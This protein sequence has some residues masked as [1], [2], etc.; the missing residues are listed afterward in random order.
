VALVVGYLLFEGEVREVRDE[1]TTALGAMADLQ[2]VQIESWRRERAGDAEFVATGPYNREVIGRLLAN[3]DQPALRAAVA[4]RAAMIN[5]LYAY[6]TV[7]LV[8]PDGRILSGTGERADVLT[9]SER[10]TAAQAIARGGPVFGNIERFGPAPRDTSIVVAAPMLD[11]AGHA[12]AVLL[13]RRNPQDDILPL[14]ERWPAFSRTAETMLVRR[15]GDEAR[16]LSRLRHADDEPLT[17]TIALARKDVVG[18]QALLAGVS[19]TLEGH[20]Y[21]GV[22]V[23]AVV[24]P[25]PGTGWMLVAKIDRDEILADARYKLRTAALII[26]LAALLGLVTFLAYFGRRQREYYREMYASERERREAEEETR[27]TLYSIGDAVIT[28]DADA[29]VR[30]M[31]PVAAELTGWVEQEAKGRPLHEI[32]RIVD[33]ETRRSVSSPAARALRDGRVVE[34]AGHVLLLARD[35]REIPIAD[36]A[37]PIRAVAGGEASGV[38]LVFRDQTRE[39]EVQK[40]LER[41]AQRLRILF[42]QAQDGIVVIVDGRVGEANS[43]FAALL[44][45]TPEELSALGVWDWDAELDTREK[46]FARYPQALET[47]G[48]FDAVMRRKDGTLLNVEISH[49]P[50]DWSGRRATFCIVRDTSERVR[51]QEALRLSEQQFREF[52]EFVPQLTW[53]ADATGLLTYHNRRWTDYTGLA[54]TDA[55][56]TGWM[57]PIHPDDLPRLRVEWAAALKHGRPYAEECRVRRSDGEYRWHLVRGL[58][59]LD[60][61]GRVLRWIGYVTDIQDMKAARETIERELAER[62]RDL[63][64]ARDQATA[65]NRVKD[66]F[67][68]AMSHE[69]RTPL[70]SIIGFS[71][72]LLDG[73]TG[74]LTDEQRRQVGIVHQSGQHLLGLI[75]DVLDISRIESGRLP[76]DLGPIALR[77][78]IEEQLQAVETQAAERGLAVEAELPDASLIVV[79]DARRV[80]QVLM[81][82]LSNAIKYSDRGCITVRARVAGGHARVEVQDTGIGIP[83]EELPQL[84]QPFHRLPLPKGTVREGTGLGL[85]ISRRLVTA[86][87]GDIGVRSEPGQ[88]S[89]FWFT[90]PLA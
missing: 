74:P 52:A 78:L 61:A 62:T 8:T 15:D 49:A 48:R 84:F 63:V 28:T 66:V 29:R 6:V 23:L 83:A 59:V 81:N 19:G 67:L 35:G 65:A 27:A 47:P 43:A 10:D 30:R 34:L 1:R 82:L 90:L 68:A 46:Y 70:N 24:R 71:A 85:A 33:E 64:A 3:P 55:I 79:G 60:A 14:V 36:S 75:S 87:G 42:D 89:C 18:V 38:V 7:L 44:G 54:V 51:M 37:A 31:N 73:L 4:E 26:A 76:L 41:D 5:R 58:P 22:D 21:R 20:D 40:A 16:Y 32:F 69:L 45:R 50:V 86:M 77:K 9:R 88:G 80:R 72:L 25:V 56:G 13:L 11:D 2:I 17:K 39:R 57:E 53:M 12:M